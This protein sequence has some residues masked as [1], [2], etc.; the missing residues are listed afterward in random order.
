MEIYFLRISIVECP[1]MDF[2]GWISMLISTL[3]WIMKDWH[4]KVMNIRMDNRVFLGIHVYMLWILGPGIASDTCYY[5][6]SALVPR[7]K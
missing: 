3:V 7:V 1:C 5:P 2:P 6:F 4:P